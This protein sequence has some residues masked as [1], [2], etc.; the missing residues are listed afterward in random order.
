ME[1]KCEFSSDTYYDYKFYTC[2][3]KEA[4]IT[5][6]YTKIKDIIG[7][8][9]PGKSHE[10][11]EAIMFTGANV[12]SFPRGLTKIFPALKV[13]KM[14]NCGLKSITRDELKG[15]EKLEI[16][17]LCCN[18]LQWL[19]SNLLV[20][21]TKLKR[22]SFYNNALQR[23]S[24]KLLHPIASNDLESVSFGCCYP[25]MDSFF[26]PEFDGSKSLQELKDI[27]DARCGKPTEKEELMCKV[28]KQ[29][30]IDRDFMNGFKDLWETKNFS[31][32]IIVV[33][34]NEFAV[35]KCVLGAQSP[36]FTAIFMN[37]MKEKQT[38]MM[39]I[40][41]FT[42]DVVEG[43][44]KFMYTGEVKDEKYAMDL[45][46]IAAKYEVKNLKRVTKALIL[47]NLDDSNALEVYGLG[48]L[49]KS[50]VLKRRGFAT[51]QEMFPEEKLHDSLM[52][53]PEDLREIIEYLRKIQEFQ[54]KLKLKLSQLKNSE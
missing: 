13:L 45:F 53:M 54:A 52:E 23:V 12:H 25:K 44:L 29:K 39:E 24:S 6:P 3:V 8:H 2:V 11:V 16:L 37:D 20:G 9:Q 49:H 22:I 19:P 26:G 50:D 31:D 4:S 48:Y 15:L 51:I 10:D 5:K 33:G 27:I 17:E 41:D 32:F 7:E 30:V 34:S 28:Y 18:Q 21:M 35:H 38:G 36:I 43:M 40:V 42:A 14:C 1:L 46:A 47:R